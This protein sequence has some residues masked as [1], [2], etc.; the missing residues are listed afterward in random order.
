MIILDIETT[1]I[2][3]NKCG[4]WQIGALDFYNPEN[5][6][7]EE[8]RI[9]D[10]DLIEEGALKIN[11]KIEQELRDPKKQSQKQLLEN[12]FEWI[13]EHKDYYPGGENIGTFDWIFLKEKSEKY[14]LKFPF[15]ARVFD[16]Q[17]VSQTRY[18]QIF[19][20]LLIKDGKSDMGLAQTLEFCGL[21]DLRGF[22]NAL[23]DCKLEA[24]AF[25]RLLYGKNLI[26]EFSKFPVSEYLKKEK[27]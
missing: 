5:Y 2:D 4:I 21:K 9:D 22:H 12:F 1:G 26:P 13:N 14:E 20:K 3:F 23:E 16:L 7:L 25:S 19:G 6:F 15:R 18:H 24:E 10:E 17:A 8:A 27:K 11:G